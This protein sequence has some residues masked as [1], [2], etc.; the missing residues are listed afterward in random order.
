MTLD[1]LSTSL[2]LSIWE[3]KRREVGTRFALIGS[4]LGVAALVAGEHL[5]VR[6]GLP[7]WGVTFLGVLLAVPAALVGAFASGTLAVTLYDATNPRPVVRDGL[8][9]SPRPHVRRPYP[10]VP[11]EQFDR[12]RFGSN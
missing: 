11:G 6:Y 2:R 1:H 12:T 5:G 9:S 4:F 10:G 3:N 8:P 7:W